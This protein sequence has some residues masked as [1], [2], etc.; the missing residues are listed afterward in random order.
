MQITCEIV[1]DLLFIYRF[2]YI[3]FKLPAGPHILIRCLFGRDVRMSKD[4]VSVFVAV[5]VNNLT[6]QLQ[7]AT[8]D[9]QSLSLSAGKF[10]TSLF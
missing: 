3:I 9:D 7:R 4:C 8:N 5:N 2:D 10:N 1:V 6:W